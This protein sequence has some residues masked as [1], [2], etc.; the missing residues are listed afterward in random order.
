[1]LESQAEFGKKSGSTRKELKNY[2]AIPMLTTFFSRLVEARS[3]N[4]VIQ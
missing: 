1:M 3:N 2:L 4:Y